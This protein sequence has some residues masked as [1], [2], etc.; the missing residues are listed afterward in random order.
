M[1]MVLIL[2]AVLFTGIPVAQAAKDYYKWTDENGVTHYSAR[3]P[4]DQTAEVI[5]IRTGQRVVN[6][7]STNAEQGTAAKPAPGVAGNGASTEN[8]K[9]PERC[10][11][12]RTNLET[13]RNNARVRMQNED[14]EIY[15]LSEEEKAEKT[16]QFEKA[17][18]ESC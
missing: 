13:L 5:S 9:D 6:P 2:S 18:A 8:L 4:H 10:E 11:N 12:A 1:R 16:A 14:G 17:V 7:S 15:Y 3:K